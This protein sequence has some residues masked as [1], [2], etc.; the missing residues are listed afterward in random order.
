[1]K[2]KIK[3]YIVGDVNEY[4]ARIIYATTSGKA[5]SYFI[6]EPDCDCCWNDIYARRFPEYDQYYDG[7]PTKDFWNIPEHRIKLVR[8]YGWSCEETLNICKKCPAI[9]YCSLWNY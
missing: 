1:M 3:A 2:E 5:K 4:S 7:N 9:Q 6:H 8:D